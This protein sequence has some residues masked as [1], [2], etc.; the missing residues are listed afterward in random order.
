LTPEATIASLPGGYLVQTLRE[1]GEELVQDPHIFTD[2]EDA[3]GYISEYLIRHS[4]EDDAEAL[5]RH[6]L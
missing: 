6:I 5:E 3:F 2:L 4:G 1:D